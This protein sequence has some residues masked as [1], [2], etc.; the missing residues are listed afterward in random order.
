[1][2]TLVRFFVFSWLNILCLIFYFSNTYATQIFLNNPISNNSQ[3]VNS[4]LDN[5]DLVS[6]RVKPKP[7][8]TVGYEKGMGLVADMESYNA[9]GFGYDLLAKFGHFA[10]V[11]FKFVEIKGSLID[12]VKNGI[13]DIGGLYS[14]NP[15]NEQELAFGNFPLQYTQYA[16]TTRGENDYFY[17]DPQT[18]NGKTVATFPENPGI[19][20]LN[21]YL[22]ENNISVKYVYGDVRTYT[23]LDADFYLLPSIKSTDDSFSSVLNL[24]LKQLFFFTRKGNEA[25]MNYFDKKFL[26]FF[27]ENIAFYDVLSQK[28]RGVDNDFRNRSLTKEEYILLKN[29]TYRVGYIDNHAPFQSVDMLGNIEG[30]SV[31]VMNLLSKKYG[32][33]IEYVP[34]NLENKMESP[35][36]L[37]ILIS[38]VGDRH[39]IA[40]F[41][42]RTDAYA[43]NDLVIT[44]QKNYP[45]LL[46]D[47]QSKSG[48]TKPLKVGVL[49]YITFRYN[50]LNSKLPHAKI[51]HYSTSDEL[52]SAFSNQE[53]DAI[54]TTSAGGDSVVSSYISAKQQYA[55]N[56][57]LEMNFYISKELGVE[58]LEVFNTII[59]KIPAQAINAITVNELAK[60]APIFGTEQ[61][62][63]NNLNYFILFGVFLVVLGVGLVYI[64]RQRSA[65]SSL[66]KD[67]IT[68]L[69]SISQF[70]K[71]VDEL[72]IK[73]SPLEYELIMLDIDYFRL[74]NN[75][76]GTDRGTEVIKAMAEALIDAYKGTKV[77]LSRRIAE[78]FVV[79][80]KISTGRKIE[81][82]INTFVEP[83]IKSIIGSGYS[84]KMSIGSCKNTQK[85]K[86]VNSLF[87]NATV[88]K[89]KAKKIHK[90]SFLEF[91][92]EMRQE[93]NVMLDIIY[94][95]EPAIKNK[96]FKVHYQPKIDFNSLKIMGAE[97]L[98]RWIPP[99]G[100][101]IYPN[102]FIPVMEKNG[103]ISQLE[104]YVFEEVCSFIQK[105][106]NQIKIPKI[107]VNVSL[108]TLT[109]AQLIKEIVKIL[110]DYKIHPTQIEI[111][112][113][114]SA[115]GDFEE[116][117][118]I[119]I[120]ILHKVGFT[121][122]MDDFG[123]GNSSLNRLSVINVDVL[124]LDKAFIDFHDEAPRGYAVVKQMIEL[125]KQLD[126]KV[127]AEGIEKKE[128]AK[129]LKEMNCDIAQ[130]FYFA[131]VLNESDFVNL[132]M[133]N[134]QYSLT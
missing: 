30:I 60:F 28:Y 69:K 120:K 44:F 116:V 117:L 87:D 131:K 27:I 85:D 106:S 13:V 41:Y 102:D 77:I 58:Y 123:A 66:A 53:V 19:A 54:I 92:D 18:I 133:D 101:P 99:I 46:L 114:E 74:I 4:E 15:E 70:S 20:F 129:W 29:H 103:F 14:K 11:E 65:I 3:T 37:D 57:P 52:L 62:I 56:I 43:K 40:R 108:I 110:K 34:Y 115:I 5:I 71:E 16:L 82:V 26:Q 95:M 68:P 119:I 109:N 107:A 21:K 6:K 45:V 121:V 24:D 22:S 100:N 49:N 124:K 79:F 39:H 48:L 90:T 59:N 38:L 17:N 134:K 25:L 128:Q 78:Q 88:A 98:T 35:E 50:E 75:Y 73:A 105:N 33:N 55:L 47:K 93:A 86:K 23:D 12:A 125:A 64:I 122:A 76:Y 91:N 67:D 2:S 9:K 32:F 72:L 96:E 113:T 112:I 84:L 31:R 89:L 51:I 61:F 83:R 36:D 10:N 127:V 118:P 132:L 111:E 81:E 1:M 80:K 104:L 130:G 126:M 97:A 7:V 63:K 8:I 94:R 42:N